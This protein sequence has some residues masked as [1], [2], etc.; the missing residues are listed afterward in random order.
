MLI[1][2]GSQIEELLIWKA[3]YRTTQSDERDVIMLAEDK[4]GGPG[5]YG[6]KPFV[7]DS[8]PD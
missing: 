1:L 4:L 2:A 7:F 8:L 6:L 3:N 5:E